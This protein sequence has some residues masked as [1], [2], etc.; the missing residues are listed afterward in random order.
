MLLRAWMLWYAGAIQHW[1]AADA[2]LTAHPEL[3]SIFKAKEPT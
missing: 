3:I 2:L 1:A